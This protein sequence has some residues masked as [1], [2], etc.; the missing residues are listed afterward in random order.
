MQYSSHIVVIVFLMQHLFMFYVFMLCL[1]IV[2]FCFMRYGAGAVT[3]A[4]CW[5]FSLL[6]VYKL[7]IFIYKLDGGNYYPLSLPL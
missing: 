1:C 3:V 7:L 6:F 4:K 2:S 5:V